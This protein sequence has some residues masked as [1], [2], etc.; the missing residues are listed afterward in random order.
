MLEIETSQTGPAKDQRRDSQ[1]DPTNVLR[2]PDLGRTT[3]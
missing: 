3:D 1:T 2:E